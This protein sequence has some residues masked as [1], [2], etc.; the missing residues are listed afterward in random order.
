MKKLRSDSAWRKLTPEQQAQLDQWRFDENLSY[1]EILKQADAAFGVKASIPSLARFLG[2]RELMRESLEWERKNPLAGR[3]GAGMTRDELEGMSLHLAAM[4]AYELSLAK[5]GKLRVK[6]LHGLMKILREERRLALD[7]EVKAQRI[8]I[9]ELQAI[10]R[11]SKDLPQKRSAA[12]WKQLFGEAQQILK[13]LEP[14]GG[15]AAVNR[16]ENPR[17][18]AIDDGEISTLFNAI[19]P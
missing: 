18:T 13:S 1:K 2:R 19:Q 15:K 4:A 16:L 7:R 14:R 17:R 8:K 6:D 9:Q 10:T 3:A 11:A 12:G 5:P